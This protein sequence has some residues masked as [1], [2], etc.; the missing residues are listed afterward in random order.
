MVMFKVLQKIIL[1]PKLHLFLL[2]PLQKPPKLLMYLSMFRPHQYRSDSVCY[3]P[4]SESVNHI[5]IPF[6][7]LR[8]INC[9]LR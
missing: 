6:D 2:R 5:L 8:S 1:A 3:V 7:M 9:S 4:I